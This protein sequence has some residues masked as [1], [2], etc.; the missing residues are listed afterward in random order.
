VKDAEF[1]RRVR[2]LARRKKITFQFVADNGK[3]S[4]SRFY[5]GEEFTTLK[6]RNKESAATCWLRCAKMCRD[7]NIDSHDL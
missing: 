6:Y 7:L 5:C 3:G 1:E 2:K 4:H